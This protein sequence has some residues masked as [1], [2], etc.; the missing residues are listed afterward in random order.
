MKLLIDVSSVL[1]TGLFVGVDKEFGRVIAHEGKDVQVNG[2]MYGYDNAV[3]YI[4]EVMETLK[5]API[6]LI[7]VTEKKDAIARRRAIYAGYKLGRESRPAEYKV[8]I[9][10][11]ITELTSAFRN[12]GSQVVSQGGAEADDVLAYLARK[13]SGEIV[14]LTSD[15]DMTT[16][17]NDRVSLWQGNRLTKENKYGPFPCKY[18]PVY[19]ALVGD[20]KEYKGAVGFGD[21]AFLDMLVAFGDGGLAAIEGMMKRGCEAGEHASTTPGT[22]IDLEEDVAEF[23]PFRKV[24]DGATHV[25]QSYTCALLHDEWVDTPRVPLTWVDADGSKTTDSRLTKWTTDNTGAAQCEWWAKLHPARW[26]V[27]KH[28]A[29]FDC[30]LLGKEHPV[31]LVCVTVIETGEEASFWWHRDGDMARLHDMLKRPNLRWVS[32]NGIHFD[33]PIISAAIDGKPPKVLKEIAHR[34]INENGRSWHMASEFDYTPIEFD[35]VDLIEVAPGV[36]ISLK[37]YAGR[38]GY[39]TMVDMPFHHDEDLNVGQ[40]VVVEDYCKN[41][42]G[43]TAALF[44]RLRSEIDLR[45]EMSEEHGIDLR[46]KSDAQVAEAVLKKAANIGK[47]EEHTPES[48]TYKAPDFIETDSDEINE[49]IERLQRTNFMINRA[50]GQVEAPEFL[51]DVLCIGDGTYQCGVGGLHSTHDK[52]LYRESTEEMLISDFDVASYYPNIMLKAG[53]TPRL[54][55]GSGAKFIEE[56]QHIYDR[57]LEAK[58]A[59]NMKVSNALKISLNGTFG[60][61]GSQF[62]SFYS[63]DLMLAV[64]LTGQLNLLCLIYEFE[65][66]PSIKVLSANTDGVTVM[67]PAKFRDLIL[68]KVAENAERTGFEY[69]ETRY[70]KIAMKDVN[71]YLAI[72]VD[73]KVKRKGLYAA[74]GLMKNPTMQVCSD[75]AIEYLKHGTHPQ[76][77]IYGHDDMTDFV[78]VRAVK[79]GG[80]Q[81]HT[82]VEVD[83]WVLV[84][85]LGNKDNGWFR[86]AWF[87][88]GFKVKSDWDQPQGGD[89]NAKP[90]VRRKSRPNPV[91]VGLGG[92]PFGRMARWY[93][94]NSSQHPINYI[95]S[96]NKVPKTDGA[97][98]CMTLPEELPEDL[99]RDWYVKETLSL[100]ADMG[101]PVP[102]TI[103][104]D[105]RETACSPA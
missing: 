76:V 75:M 57:R 78:A 9:D 32:F 22:L 34:L 73:G 29:V 61:L 12:V 89:S 53:L 47:R 2:W 6:D 104:V 93:M 86:Q 33:A 63:P 39:P 13:L 4:L 46:S 83:D 38:M 16:L 62:S 50:N 77:A 28:H 102:K 58:R 79:G 5:L 24:I 3:K 27:E 103:E 98:V 55:N 17:I 10:R 101:V 74:K 66:R 85:D 97:K 41:D 71:N 21:G 56:Y 67:Y 80:I 84:E 54:S 91:Q 70:S 92:K 42:L 96:G 20:G 52:C 14:I 7:F 26:A 30:E 69:E 87:D 49:L 45:T 90:P 60:K 64:T 36:R 40:M 35:H 1:K 43:V 81:H 18:T 100:L 11:A 37:A 82:F 51:K 95:K 65:C 99:D 25:Y 88:Q 59:G 23:K 72:T 44:G 68:R 105:Q 8:E 48:V 19:K 31:F 15:G 94:C